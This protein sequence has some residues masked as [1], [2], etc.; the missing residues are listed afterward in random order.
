MAGT[1]FAYLAAPTADYETPPAWSGGFITNDAGQTWRPVPVPDGMGEEDFAGFFLRGSAVQARYAQDDEETIRETVDGGRT[2]RPADP[3]CPGKGACIAWGRVRSDGPCLH[4]EHELPIRYST[5]GGR[6]FH[7]P[8]WP[9]VLDSCWPASIASLTDGRILLLDGNEVSEVDFPLRISRD[10]GRTWRVVALPALP[11]T[12]PNERA[13]WLFPRIG[14]LPDGRLFTLDLFHE[15]K[16]P[17][18][19][20]PGGSSWCA[21]TDFPMLAMDLHAVGDEV[22][23]RE[24]PT[25]ADPI[26][27]V[28]HTPVSQVRCE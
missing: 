16:T 14:I 3:G 22:W 13:G 27:P 19:L 12:G 24:P 20:A 26:G 9:A 5:D 25:A 4:T 11:G 28:Q 1:L 17:Y 6:S 23:W 21:A 7:S 15:G 8:D 10:G 2:W 18:L